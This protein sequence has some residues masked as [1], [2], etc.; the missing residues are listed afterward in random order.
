MEIRDLH[1]WNVSPAEAVA[2]QKRLAAQVVLEGEPQDVRVGAGGGNFNRGGGGG[3]GGAAGGPRRGRGGHFD[4]RRPWPG[5]RRPAQLS[6]AAAA[7]AAGGG[8]R[9]HVPL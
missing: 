2:I 1:P 5:C 7:G 9:A 8:G 4:R 6:R 3:G